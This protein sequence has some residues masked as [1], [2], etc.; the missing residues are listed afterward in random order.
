MKNEESQQGSSV[1]PHGFV[2]SVNCAIEGI[3]YAVKNQ[4]HMR[5]HFLVALAILGAVL[6][7]RVS[8][9]EFTLLAITVSFVLFAELVNTAIEICIDIVCPDFHPLA[10]AAKD[11]AAGAVLTAAVGAAVMGYLILSRY[12]FPHYREALGM[13]GTPSEMGTLVAILSVVLTVVILKALAGKGRP[14]AG[15]SVSGHAAV[16]FAIATA[17]SLK[18]ADPMSSILTMV[19]AIIV[20]RSRIALRL[21]TF[22]EVVAGALL[23]TLLSLILLLFLG[24]I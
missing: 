20:S 13:I 21:H 24:K 6:L 12:I 11:V 7:L 17:V 19:L 4:R 10:K 3:L 23:G 18:T 22:R 5:N 14:L 2:D 16:S 1:K 15:G 9:L 8:S